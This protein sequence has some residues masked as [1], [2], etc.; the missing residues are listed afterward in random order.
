[1]STWQSP[2]KKQ[3]INKYGRLY[4]GTELKT[5]INKTKKNYL[6]QNIHIG[7]AAINTN[8]NAFIPRVF[9]QYGLGFDYLGT[10]S[11]EVYSIV[12]IG[13][14]IKIARLSEK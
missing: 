1:M 4:L 7:L 9:I 12:Q 10:Y 6:E 2:T 3:I 13:L 8:R 5:S 14:N 11:T